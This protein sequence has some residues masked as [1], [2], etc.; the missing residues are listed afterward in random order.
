[1]NIKCL[2]RTMRVK[3]MP[4]YFMHIH[5][6]GLDSC[7]LIYWEGVSLLSFTG[8]MPFLVLNSRKYTF[9]A[10]TFPHPPGLL[11]GNG[12]RSL[13]S[14]SSIWIH[15]FTLQFLT[16]LPAY[17][18]KCKCKFLPEN[19]NNNATRVPEWISSISAAP[20]HLSGCRL[21]KWRNI[22]TES[23]ANKI[24]VT[25]SLQRGQITRS[26]RQDSHSFTDKKSRTFPGI[27]RTPWKIFQDLFGARECLNIKKKTAFTYNIQSVVHCR[28]FSMKQNVLHYCCLFSIWTTRKMYDFQGYFSR[29]FQDFKL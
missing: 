1:M 8:Q 4:V 3:N 17:Y 2:P 25:V 16:I 19:E 9:W 20:S 22:Q 18:G 13:T 15:S 7:P 12:R 28:K 21:H 24:T 23:Q 27:S 14:V 11:N 10:S 29:T 5:T 6:I 26:H